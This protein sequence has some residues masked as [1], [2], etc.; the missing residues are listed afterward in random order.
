MLRIAVT[1]QSPEAECGM[2]VAGQNNNQCVWIDVESDSAG[3]KF[4]LEAYR[5]AKQENLF[6]A[7]LMMVEKDPT[8]DGDGKAG[9]RNNP[10]YMDDQGRGVVRIETDEEDKLIFRLVNSTQAPITID[11]EN[12][13]PEFNGFLPEHESAFDDGDVEY[14]FTVTDTVSGIPEPEDL[15]GDTDGDADYMPLVALIANGQCHTKDPNKPYKMYSYAGNSVWCESEPEIRQVVDDRDF[16]EIDDGFEVATKVVLPENQARYV[17]F[18]VCDNAGNCAMYTPDENKEKEGFAEITIDTEDPDLIEA[19]TGVKWDSTDSKYD[20]DPTFIQLL[21]NDLTALD[22]TSVETDDFDVEGHTVKAVHWY[23]VSDNDDDTAWGDGD[24]STSPS[25]FADGGSMTKRGHP[26]RR[27][28]RNAVFIELEDQLAPDETPDV[29]IVPNGVLDSAGNE[30]DD[31]DVEADDWIAP[32]FTVVSMMSP[33]TPDGSSNQL[34]GD[35]DEVKITLTSNERI[36]AD[37]PDDR[38]NLCERAQGLRQH[39][40]V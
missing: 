9:T 26:L 27:S 6:I 35:G 16:D 3:N 19:R 2:A 15:S 22:P 1:A 34:A 37:P 25:R 8:D 31:D 12:E 36:Q 39:R 33:S 28:I 7:A 5:S 11:V 13:N 18:I 10:V 14:T 40:T 30:Q 20:D 29:T 17:T 32:S 23:D 38:G 21:F 24:D 4:R